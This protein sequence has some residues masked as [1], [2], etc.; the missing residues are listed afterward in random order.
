MK[1]F[2]GLILFM[3]KRTEHAEISIQRYVPEVVHIITSE[4]LRAEHEMNLEKW[5]DQ[6]D[7]RQGG[8]KS[9]DD[10]FE[11]T[12]VGSLLQLVATIRNEE[13]E[14]GPDQWYVGLTGGTMHMAA[15][16]VYAS[17]LMDMQPFYV[18]RPP[19][20]TKQMPNRD[21]LEF[22]AFKGISSVLKLMPPHLS[23]I[24]E[25]KGTIEEMVESGLPGPIF[26]DLV[27]SDVINLDKEEMTWTITESGNKI[28]EYAMETPLQKMFKSMLEE[29]GEDPSRHY[30]A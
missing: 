8:V 7:L 28:V 29:K 20:G 17:I 30:I 5:G 19:I 15:T 23:K 24:S 10:L 13:A 25:G 21:V 9:I 14:N 2:C 27:D 3:G 18:I 26:Y 4:E 1:D 11:S 16:A 12:G 6:Y 22:P